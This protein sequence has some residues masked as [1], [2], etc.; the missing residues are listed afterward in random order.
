MKLDRRTTILILVV[1]VVI[2]ST[3]VVA[4]SLNLGKAGPGTKQSGGFLIIAGPNGYN[5]SIDHGV[6]QNPWPIVK[7]QKGTTVTIS[8]YNS[9]H[10]AHGFQI[11]HYL[12]GSINTV[13]PGQTFTVS[14]VADETGTFQIYCAIFCTVHAFMQSGELIVQ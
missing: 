8:V 13:A 10:Q 2:S 6:P 11:T 12:A 14:F 5:D 9:D 1:A 3:L 7:V 4:Y